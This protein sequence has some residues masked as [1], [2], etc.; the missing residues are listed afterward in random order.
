MATIVQD[1]PTNL[2]NVFQD[3]VSLYRQLLNDADFFPPELDSYEVELPH[4]LAIGLSD[5]QIGYF[6][7]QAQFLSH[8]AVCDAWKEPR[9]DLPPISLVSGAAFGNMLIL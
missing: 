4:P 7:A 6:I 9:T 2:P 3:R 8:R 5:D 1:H